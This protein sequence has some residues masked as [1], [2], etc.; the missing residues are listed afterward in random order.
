M[1]HGFE[2][3][4]SLLDSPALHPPGACQ[5]WGMQ[6]G[7]AGGVRQAGSQPAAVRSTD[8]NGLSFFPPLPSQPFPSLPSQAGLPPTP[9]ASHFG[10]GKGVWLFLVVVCVCCSGFK[11]G[12]LRLQVGEVEGLGESAPNP[13]V[14]PLPPSLLYCLPLL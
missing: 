4:L 7:E 12:K 3:F 13:G 9:L 6:L 2:L 1:N 5:A 14:P 10:G 11:K 8:C